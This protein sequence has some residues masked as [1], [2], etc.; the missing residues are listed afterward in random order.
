MRQYNSVSIV[1]PVYNEKKS[2]PKI[3]EKVQSANC[4]GLRKEIVVVDDGS[5]DGT[6]DLL[7]KIRI[8]GLKKIYLEKNQGK[9][10]ALRAG[11]AHASGQIIIVQDADLEYNPADYP[12]LLSPILAGTSEVVYGSRELTINTHSYP[13]FFLGGKAITLVTRVLYGGKITDVPTGYKVFD[14]QILMKRPL[15]CRRFE[16]CPEVTAHL[17]KRGIQIVEVPIRY[18][19]RTITQGKKIKWQDGIEAILTLIRVRLMR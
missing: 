3:I 4:L 17:L 8:K 11:F 10:S 16:F 14:R 18:T 2:L 7:K 5:T 1:I 13:L 9:G 15:Q 12:V 19:P 6:G